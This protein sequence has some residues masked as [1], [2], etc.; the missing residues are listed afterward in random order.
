MERYGFVYIWF[1]RKHKRY[2]IGS[3]W[4]TEDDGYICSSRWMRKAYKRRPEDFKR[5]I[6]SKVFTDR[7]ELLNKEF[8]WLS[9]IED[10][11][12][13]YKYYN[14]TKHKNGHWVA[15]D[16]EK[17]IRKRISQKTKEAM[18]RPEIK[19]KYQEGL[20]SR[21]NRSSD[22]E[23]R[24][25]RRQSMIK[26]MAEK[27]PEEDRKKYLPNDSQE[28]RNLLSEKSKQL[29]FNRTEEQLLDVGSKISA[30]LKGKQ[31]RLGHK[32]TPEHTAKI[33]ESNKE[34]AK[35]KMESYRL[36]IEQTLHMTAVDA[37]KIVGIGRQ[38]INKY[39]KELG[40]I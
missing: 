18:Q 7:K 16:Y 24:E 38:I 19:Q 35:R 17:N 12:L 2:Y 33:A 23:V 11:Q 36:L 25:K 4:G 21:D 22:I 26:T 13:K 39:R 37:S 6:I 14:A 34:R 5:R 20:K 8:E 3:H 27:F 31:N 29:W 30:S 9:L 1:D 28:Y 10:A 32:N 40:Y 15:E